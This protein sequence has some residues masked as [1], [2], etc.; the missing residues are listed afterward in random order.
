MK[1][2]AKNVS[3][4]AKRKED[5]NYDLRR[6]LKQQDELSEEEVDRLVSD[7]TRRV[8]ASFDCTGCANCCKQLGRSVTEQ[9]VQRLAAALVLSE[10]DFRSRYLEGKVGPDEDD[11]GDDEGG[12]RWRLRGKPCPFLKDD[13]CTV[14][15]ARPGQCRKYPYLYEPNF[16]FRTLGMIERTFTCPIVY[17]V[18]E[19][20]KEELPFRRGGRAR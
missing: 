11:E 7:I 4:L 3:T 15:E 17:H 9:E 2:N 14:Y 12:M 5:E 20:L 13:R 18:L 6:Y 8:W 10:E 16:S 19:E 1:A